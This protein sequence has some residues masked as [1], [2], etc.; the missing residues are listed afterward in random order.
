M[1]V[2]MDTETILTVLERF[3][4]CRLAREVITFIK[5]CTFSVRFIVVAV[6][7]EY[8]KVQLVLQKNRYFL[9]SALP[10]VLRALLNDEIIS[11]AHAL[12]GK[13]AQDRMVVKSEEKI[14]AVGSVSLYEKAPL[15]PLTV[16]QSSQELLTIQ[17]DTRFGA[18]I[19]L[20]DEITDTENISIQQ[21]EIH[22]SLVEEVRKRCG[23]LE[24]PLM[25][26][27]DFRNDD[28]NAILDIDLSPRCQIRDY[29]ETCLSKMFG[30]NG[31]RAR[32]GIIVLPTVKT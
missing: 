6:N 31:G 22:K 5:E 26:E 15:P 12:V 8:G 4:K 27:Y 25:E 20:D 21:F 16:T 9:E 10:T 13:E 30:G 2:G 17:K 14:K 28:E 24:Y 7:F 23:E 11:G 19:N 29:Q 18:I 1:A 3:S 32:S